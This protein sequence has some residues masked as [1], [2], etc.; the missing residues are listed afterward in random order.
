M[1][2]V[3]EMF[4]WEVIANEKHEFDEKNIILLANK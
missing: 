2:N 1:F 3:C 4:C